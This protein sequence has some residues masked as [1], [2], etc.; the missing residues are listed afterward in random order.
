MLSCLFETNVAHISPHSCDS[1]NHKHIYPLYTLDTLMKREPCSGW[2]RGLFIGSHTHGLPGYLAFGKRYAN[3][4]KLH[5]QPPLPIDEMKFMYP[6]G[7]VHNAGKVAGLYTY[8]SILNRLLRKTITPRGGNPADISL[9]ARNLLAT[10]RPS[11]A[12]FCV[13]DF[14]WEEIKYISENPLKIC[15]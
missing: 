7:Q 8:Y 10:L 13:A 12:D 5:L 6:K 9:H 3:R 11:G 14:I 15:G 1:R 2:Q 4:P